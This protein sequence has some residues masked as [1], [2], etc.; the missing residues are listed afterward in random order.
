M[1]QFQLTTDVLSDKLDLTYVNVWANREILISLIETRH[2]E[3]KDMNRRMVSQIET[4]NSGFLYFS[5]KILL[6]SRLY[7][8][9]FRV[10]LLLS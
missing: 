3:M 6:Y 8:T 2:E 5:N 10:R 7:M 9:L 1:A 4:V